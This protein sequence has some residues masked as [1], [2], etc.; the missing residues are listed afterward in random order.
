[1][2]GNTGS[3]WYDIV[4]I[5]GVVPL[6]LVRAFAILLLSSLLGTVLGLLACRRIPVI[7]QLLALYASL[8]R[9]IPTLV[10]L[11]FWYFLLPNTF[12]KAAGALHFGVDSNNVSA[13]FVLVFTYTLCYSAYMMQTAQAALASLP[14]SQEALAESLGYSKLQKFWH[15]M[16]PQALLYALPNLCNT[17]ISIIKA[18]SLGFTIAVVDIFA[19]AKVLA[20]LG[21]NY[22]LVYTA[23]AIVYWAVCGTFAWAADRLVCR[24]GERRGVFAKAQVASA[25]RAVA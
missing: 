23:D 19:E 3:L 24:V 17:F 18:L 25:I 11:L 6:T 21:G 13:D 20:G 16:L 22:I 1:M 8:F 5:S 10:Q 14:A 9:G 12:A 15:V 2:S 7:H 4:Q